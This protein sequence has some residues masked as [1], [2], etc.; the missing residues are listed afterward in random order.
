MSKMSR[1][2]GENAS[3][4]EWDDVSEGQRGGAVK[5]TFGAAEDPAIGHTTSVTRRK[6]NKKRTDE[7]C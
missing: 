3:R 5:R 6:I 1:A 2:P 4:Q 7:V